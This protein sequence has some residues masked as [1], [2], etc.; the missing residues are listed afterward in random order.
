MHEDQGSALSKGKRDRVLFLT[1]IRNVIHKIYLYK[2]QNHLGNRNK[3]R[4]ATGKPEAT[5]LTAE[6]LYIDLNGDRQQNK[7]TK[8]IGMFGKHPHNE[9]FLKDMSLKQKI[10][11]YSEESQQFL[12]DMNQTEIF[13]LCE[14]SAKHQ[15]S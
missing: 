4:R 12:A 14:N 7:V 1:L 2:K 11:K 6:Y 9:Q 5:Q 15:W 10:N 13:E 8:L 3:M